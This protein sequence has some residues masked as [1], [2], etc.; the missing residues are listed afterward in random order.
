[1]P[2]LERTLDALNVTLTNISNLISLQQGAGEAQVK[3]SKTADYH[4][5]ALAFPKERLPEYW[6]SLKKQLSRCK[7]KEKK[8][9]L[10]RKLESKPGELIPSTIEIILGCSGGEEIGEAI[11]RLIDSL[12]M[13]YRKKD[14]FKPENY[15]VWKNALKSY[16]KYVLTLARIWLRRDDDMHK[17]SL[18]AAKA[19][20]QIRIVTD[21]ASKKTKKKEKQEKS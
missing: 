16:K 20:E 12:A 18:S 17:M 6:E 14:C 1:V 7:N 10:R 5:R 19:T 3:Y 4:L 11:S 13:K 2:S 15:V 8:E 21:V 9:E